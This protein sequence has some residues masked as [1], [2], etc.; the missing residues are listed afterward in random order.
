MWSL[1]RRKTRNCWRRGRSNWPLARPRLPARPHL[2][3]R[4]R[5]AVQPQVRGGNEHD[6]L[7]SEAKRSKKADV[8][9]KK[10]V[11]T[12]PKKL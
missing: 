5:L 4:P 9:K 11:Q 12:R 8:E 3:A 7:V 10:K 1:S 6:S 2:P